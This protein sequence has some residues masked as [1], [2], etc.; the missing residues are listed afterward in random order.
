MET[1]WNNYIF[2]AIV[3][4]LLMAVIFL[5]VAIMYNV[6]RTR[7]KLEKVDSNAQRKEKEPEE[8]DERFATG[9]H[10]CT[11]LH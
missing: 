11:L 10:A 9:E 6:R 7:M 3:P 2:S 5:L 8:H 4:S 1:A